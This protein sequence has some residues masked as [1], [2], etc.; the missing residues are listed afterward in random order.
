MRLKPRKRL[1]LDS[2][3]GFKYD[4]DLIPVINHIEKL[5]DNYL[6]YILVRGENVR[7]TGMSVLYR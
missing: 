1:L 6:V 2:S 7:N 4:G 3:L 5:F